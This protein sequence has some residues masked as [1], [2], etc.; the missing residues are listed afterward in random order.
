[1]RTD[2][3]TISREYGAGASELASLL[4]ARL[5]WRVLDADIPLAVAKRLGIPSDSLE[6]WDE[7]APRFFEAMGHALLLGSPDVLLDPSFTRTPDARD[8]AAVTRELLLKEMETPPAIIVGHGAQ[9]IFGDRPRSLHLRLV[10]PIADRVRRI[11]ARRSCT[12]QE[13]ADIARRV[14][15]DRAHYVKEFLGRNVEDP[16]LYAV[17]INTGA[18]SM[19]DAVA[20]VLTLLGTDGPS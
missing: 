17:Q 7:H 4:G 2:L 5:G 8:V 19:P 11:L 16:L 13:A 15:L 9:V 10:A 14:D 1:M 6:Q 12:E 3:I 20:I 18:I